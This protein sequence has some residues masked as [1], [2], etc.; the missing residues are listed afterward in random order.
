MIRA[1]EN[2]NNPREKKTFRL[3]KDVLAKIKRLSVQ[4]NESESEII[5]TAIR[6]FKP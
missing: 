6:N 3:T 2:K 4:W 1:K 5:E